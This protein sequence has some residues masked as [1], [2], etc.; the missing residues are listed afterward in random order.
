MSWPST[1]MANNFPLTSYRSS[2][3]SASSVTLISTTHSPN[4][5]IQRLSLCL[6]SIHRCCFHHQLI[7]MEVT[8]IMTHRFPEVGEELLQCLHKILQQVKIVYH[9][10]SS[11]LTDNTPQ[12]GTC[13]FPSLSFQPQKHRPSSCNIVRKDRAMIFIMT[14]TLT[15]QTP[16]FFVYL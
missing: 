3:S 7:N 8:L 12:R 6:H 2:S 13:T 9:M 14:L 4:A 15:L 11:Y 16:N 1:I 10:F 5:F